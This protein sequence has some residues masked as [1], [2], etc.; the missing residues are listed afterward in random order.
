[1]SEFSESYHV[2]TDDAGAVK[3]RLSDAKLAGIVFGPANGWLTFVP[4]EELNDYREAGGSHGLAVR[5]SQLLNAPVLWYLHAED[6]GWTF[7]LAR[8]GAP[9][10]RFAC[11][12]DPE[13]SAE[14]D[15]LDIAVL[16][17][18]APLERLESLLRQFDI[19]AAF[20]E[21]PAH[22]FAEVLGLPAY[23]WVS[24]LIAQRHSDDLLRMGGAELGLKPSA[25]AH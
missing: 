25:A 12:W 4:Y 24:P 5:M 2:R 8:P 22:R 15:E 17:S 23:K 16:A 21:R 3:K 9:I 18:L 13:P 19:G 11:W 10:C 7:A 1:M 14:R 6:H 20:K